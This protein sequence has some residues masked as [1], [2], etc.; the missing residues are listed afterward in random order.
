M[1]NGNL[2]YYANTKM[3][4]YDTK[5]L[6]ILGLWKLI[7]LQPYNHTNSLFLNFITNG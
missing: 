5:L 7:I 3:Y 1:F 4:I 6:I 2:Q